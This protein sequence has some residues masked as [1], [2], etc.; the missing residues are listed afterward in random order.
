[1]LSNTSLILVLR[2][3]STILHMGRREQLSSHD[4][5]NEGTVEGGRSETREIALRP[6][7]KTQTRRAQATS[8]RALLILVT[9][10]S[11]RGD[12][13]SARAAERLAF[14]KAHA[15]ELPWELALPD[16]EWEC[17]T[18]GFLPTGRMCMRPKLTQCMHA[19][20]TA[21]VILLT[22][23]RALCVLL[24]YRYAH[25]ACANMVS[26]ACHSASQQ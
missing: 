22:A 3:P 21:V 12:D 5:F 15:N 10:A 6:S 20:A 18:W 4:H 1:M 7:S 2:P 26:V 8:M 23:C 13:A 11:V 17:V 19:L 24:C 14:E 16:E 9:T 25:V